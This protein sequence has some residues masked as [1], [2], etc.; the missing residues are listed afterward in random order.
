MEIRT[1]YEA[2][3]HSETINH[4]LELKEFLDSISMPT[5]PQILETELERDITRAELSAAIDSIQSGKTPRPDGL[6]IEIY[7]KLKNK[8]LPPLL[9]MFTESFLKWVNASI[10]KRS[11]NHRAPK[12]R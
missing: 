6:P 12:S 7:K 10:S 1:L 3:Y 8:L 2:L 5:I 9:K 11:F 4:N